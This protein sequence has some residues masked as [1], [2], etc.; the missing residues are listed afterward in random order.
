M[1][2]GILPEIEDGLAIGKPQEADNPMCGLSKNSR[3]VP[4]RRDGVLSRMTG[5]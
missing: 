2:R 3:R 1:T 4:A 5:A